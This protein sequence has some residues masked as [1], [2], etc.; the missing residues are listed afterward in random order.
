MGAGQAAASASALAAVGRCRQRTWCCQ[1]ALTQPVSS[2]SGGL[3]AS[4]DPPSPPPRHPPCS[5]PA[6]AAAPAAAGGGLGGDDLS[7]GKPSLGKNPH[8]EGVKTKRDLAHDHHLS[9]KGKGERRGV[10][11]W[12]G[13]LLLHARARW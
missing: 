12:R 11:L 8:S 3:S 13:L 5:C 6:A 4:T 9:R 2:S 1:L 7:S 10:G